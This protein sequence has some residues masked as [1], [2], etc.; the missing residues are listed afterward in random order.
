MAPCLYSRE[1]GLLA[2]TGMRNGRVSDSCYPLYY[3]IMEK[4]YND[5]KYNDVWKQ[6][7]YRE[8]GDAA[9]HRKT[10]RQTVAEAAYGAF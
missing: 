6:K 3:T 10:G 7:G 4:K 9:A 8:K 1:A 2:G 5:G